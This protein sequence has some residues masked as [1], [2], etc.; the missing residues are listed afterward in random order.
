VAESETA[1]C[2]PKAEADAAVEAASNALVEAVEADAE[3]PLVSGVWLT[4]D[5][6][7]VK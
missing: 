5:E 1:L 4:E 3:L 2:A 7:A 6:G